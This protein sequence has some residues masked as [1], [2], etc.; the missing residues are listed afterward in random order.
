MTKKSDTLNAIENMVREL[1]DNEL[2]EIT[3]FIVSKAC[4]RGVAVDLGLF[5]LEDV[6]NSLDI[7]DEEAKKFAQSPVK[8]DYSEAFC[9]LGNLYNYY[10]YN[11]Y[12]Y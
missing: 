5:T 12:Q 9:E 11:N 7:S 6:A 10:K 1:D 4:E 2:E 3:N 8:H